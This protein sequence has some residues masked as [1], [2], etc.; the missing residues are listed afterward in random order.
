[1]SSSN[2]LA[3]GSHVQ[4]YRIDAVLGQG[5]FAITYRGWDEH[6]KAMVAIKE[7]FPGQIMARDADGG[8]SL[9]QAGDAELFE[10]G[11]SRFVAEAQ[12]LAQ[13]RHPNIVRVVRYFVARR[14]AYIVMDYEQ[15]E[16]LAERLG[17]DATPMP[18][19]LLRGLFVALLSGLREVH[20]KRYLHR[21]VKP[22]NIYL[23]EDGSPVLLD[24]GAARM[25]F[26]SS[27]GGQQVNVLTP[28]YAPV[29]Q[30]ASDG[31]QG[32]WSDLYALGATL[33]RC[34]TGEAPVDAWKRAQIAAAGGADPFLPAVERAAG[35]YS[36][37]LL[38]AIDWSLALRAEQ[39]PQTADAVLAR[40]GGVS[41]TRVGDGASFAYVPRRAQR[42]HKLVFAGPVGA[43]KSTAIATLSH[44][45]VVATEQRATDMTADRKAQTTVAMDF[46]VMNLADD[47]RIHLYG[48]PGQ[49]RFDFMWQILEKGALGLVLL[50][51]NS[52]R[53]PL[54]DLAFYLESFKDLVARTQVAVGVTF[55]EAPSATTLDDYHL[56]FQQRRAE[57]GLNPPVF[58]VD[59]RE[60]ADLALLVEALLYSIDPGIENYDV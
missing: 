53:A 50:I 57:L 5:A 36:S 59:A 7:F 6:L 15:G 43:G 27:R 22:G 8:V 20:A 1:M 14:T 56:Y 60:R 44:T 38:D 55:S 29:E 42:I 23:R 30:Y 21:D 35:R 37:E 19:P 49:E 51:D 11:L 40:L 39:R 54:R 28:R 46:G 34:V 3:S 4:E 33:Y 48:L 13:F 47:E 32:P 52:R 16:S 9:K 26:D 17:R 12:V 25:E 24:F 58:A 10:W 45:P 41:T 18:E 31:R 2:A